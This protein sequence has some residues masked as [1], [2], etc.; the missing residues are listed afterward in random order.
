MPIVKSYLDHF[1]VRNMTDQT[2]TLGDLSLLSIAPHQR[3]DLLT[4]PRITKEKI[5][6]S[7]NL[8]EAIRQGRLRIEKEKCRKKKKSKSQREA[9][10]SDEEIDLCDIQDVSLS[11]VSNDD[12]LV[13]NSSTGHWENESPTDIDINLNVVSV[14]SDYTALIE[15]DLIL[16]DASDGALTVTLPTA[17][18]N[19]GKQMYIKKIDSSTNVIT[20]D[21]NRSEEIDS[22]TTQ[23]LANQHECMDICA[24]SSN[25]FIT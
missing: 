2:I 23:E 16:C 1:Y 25:W 3:V 10:I 22:E 20:V 12:I 8:Q 18:G 13:Y 7:H 9:T 11:G 17:A 4:V 5:N 15:N 19:D 21:G 14:S 24:D 6:Q